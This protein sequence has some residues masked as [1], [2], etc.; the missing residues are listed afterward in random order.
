[1]EKLTINDQI[2]SE[3]TRIMGE[4]E[5]NAKKSLYSIT[6]FNQEGNIISSAELKKRFSIM[7]KVLF[8]TPKYI[9]MENENVTD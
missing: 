3:S 1:M 5:T 8:E 2:I 9:I 7:I 6:N 4:E